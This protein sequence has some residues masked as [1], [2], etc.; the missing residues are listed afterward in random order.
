MTE[1]YLESDPASLADMCVVGSSTTVAPTTAA[2]LPC[3][4]DRPAKRWIVAAIT[5]GT[6]VVLGFGQFFWIV[7]RLDAVSGPL[8]RRR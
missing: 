7:V 3:W 5:S 4:Q 2:G 1:F 8:F 6:V